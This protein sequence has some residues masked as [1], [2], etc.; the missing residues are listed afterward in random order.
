MFKDARARRGCKTGN[1]PSLEEIRPYRLTHLTWSAAAR[2]SAPE[3]SLSA[4]T[5]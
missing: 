3:A 2:C 1:F 5:A 4:S